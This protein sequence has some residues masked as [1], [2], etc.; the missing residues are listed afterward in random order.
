M[1]L[2]EAKDLKLEC[3]I[4]PHSPYSKSEWVPLVLDLIYLLD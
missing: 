4:F 1:Q 3:P 2:E